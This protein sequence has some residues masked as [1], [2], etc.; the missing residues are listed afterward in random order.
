MSVVVIA[1]KGRH[2]PE[3]LA[4]LA[5]VHRL[6]SFADRKALDVALKAARTAER[7][8]VLPAEGPAAD[9]DLAA[10]LTRLMRREQLRVPI[11]YLPLARTACAK[12]YSLSLDPARALAE[13][14]RP[15]PLVRDDDGVALVGE[16][17]ITGP[18]G[19]PLVGESIVD[20]TRLRL[21]AIA[22]VVVRAT[23]REPGVAACARRAG[24]AGLF[25]PAWVA[26]RAAQTGAEAL[27]VVRDGVPAP[28]VRTRITFFRH[29][30]DWLLIP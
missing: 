16:A 27:R 5:H 6:A 23:A 17:V 29:T 7:L 28:R 2:L 8:L 22:S 12:A 19:G 20:D 1:H 14:A 11:A 24:L 25:P 13:A 18:D 4:A 15:R 9:G 30:E 3:A 21:G 26:G 10:V